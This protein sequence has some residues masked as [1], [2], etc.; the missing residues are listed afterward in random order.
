MNMY[1]NINSCSVE[2]W[3]E[4]TSWHVYHTRIERKCTKERAWQELDSQ[5][6]FISCF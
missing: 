3:Y 6:Y 1:H 2:E 5:G 4:H